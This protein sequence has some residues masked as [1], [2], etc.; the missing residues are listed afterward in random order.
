MEVEG[1][2]L[3]EQWRELKETLRSACDIERINYHLNLAEEKKIGKAKVIYKVVTPE[4]AFHQ[5]L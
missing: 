3:E 5:K 4:E 2:A 1:R